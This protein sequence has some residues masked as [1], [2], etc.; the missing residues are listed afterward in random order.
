MKIYNIE[1]NNHLRKYF[2][3]NYETYY[4]VMMDNDLIGLSGVDRDLSVIFN[5]TQPD[6]VLLNVL[7]SFDVSNSDQKSFETFLFDIDIE[8]AICL[9]DNK[10]IYAIGIV[11]SNYQYTPNKELP[12][13]KKVKWISK[14]KIPIEDGNPRIKIRPIL[15]DETYQMV[16][17]IINDALVDEDGVIINQ[18]SR[19]TKERYIRFFK[20][21]NINPYEKELLNI[22]YLSKNKGT[23]IFELQK[24]FTNV[25]VEESIESFSKRISKTFRIEANENFYTPNLFNRQIRDGHMC[26]SF[27]DELA[28]ALVETNIV[29]CSFLEEEET[30]YTISK[31]QQDSIYSRDDIEVA[32]KLL[33]KYKSLSLIG[34][35]YTGK[36]YLAHRLAFL[37][38]G[39]R[40][41]NNILNMK[42][43]KSL[44]YEDLFNKNSKSKLLRFIEHARKNS[45]ENYVIILEDCHTINFNEVFGELAYLVKN[46]NR[47]KEAS[48]DVEFYDSKYYLPKNVYVITTTRDTSEI[49]SIDSISG[50]LLFE[51]KAM[52][53]KRFINMFENYKLGSFIASTYTEVNKILM[54]MNISFNHGLFLKNSRGLNCEE[55]EVILNYKIRPILKR[56]LSES[57][58]LMVSEM[59]DFK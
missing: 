13:A 40:D 32:Y 8:D 25:D 5:D 47:D 18:P 59:L 35:W 10:Y 23:S 24:H 55:Y 28:Q 51:M 58:Y 41:I 34:D 53:N 57:E 27:K 29:N 12:H 14:K 16:E 17:A 6:K 52:Y 7:N 20:K 54:P 37:I 36:S 2:L 48:L 50:T 1:E 45:I 3:F 26:L 15:K 33:E 22:I 42:M 39:S 38:I 31:A 56:I 43:H 9:S 49:I 11:D 30:K 44:K 4:R 21:I 19:I 46:N